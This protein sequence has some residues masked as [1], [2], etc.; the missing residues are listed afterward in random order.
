VGGAVKQ[1][2]QESTVLG[3]CDLI[4]VTVGGMRPFERLVKEMDLIAGKTDEEVVMQVGSTGY[5]PINCHY[6]RFMPENEIEKLYARARVVVCHAGIGSI[7]TALKHSKALILVPRMK[8]YGEHID[9]HQLEIAR[10][11]ERRGTTVVYDISELQSALE[12]AS[13][14]PVQFTSDTS[15]VPRLKD[16]LNQLRVQKRGVGR[17]A[18][19]G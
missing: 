8:K 18:D 3:E 9:D 14:S 1:I 7:L 13:A 19:Y 15:L 12:E 10:E 6:V 11:M 4:F 5:E 17:R 2:W 16:Y